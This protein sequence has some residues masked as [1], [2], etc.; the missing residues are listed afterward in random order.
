M[1]KWEEEMR[2]LAACD[3]AHKNA[4]QDIIALEPAFHLTREKLSD[5][6]RDVLD[7]YISACEEFNY[8]YIRSAYQLGWH[9]CAAQTDDDSRRRRCGPSSEK[10][11]TRRRSVWF[12]IFTYSGMRRWQRRPSYR[13]PWPE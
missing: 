4:E 10:K 8:T 6:E 12:S 9:N 7:R 2:M 13:H 3:H 1:E 11:R 5:S